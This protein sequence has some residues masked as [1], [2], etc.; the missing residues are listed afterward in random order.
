MDNGYTL[1]FMAP[2][3]LTRQPTETP[4]LATKAKRIA[5]WMEFQS[6]FLKGVIEEVFPCDLEGGDYS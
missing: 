6:V 5:L 2:P 1:P 3:I 4:L